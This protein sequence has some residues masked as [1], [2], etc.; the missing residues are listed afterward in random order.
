MIDELRSSFI[1]YQTQQSNYVLRGIFS[2]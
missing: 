2:R 1:V